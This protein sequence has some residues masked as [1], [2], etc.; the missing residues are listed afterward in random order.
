MKRRISNLVCYD[1]NEKGQTFSISD[2]GE[3][4]SC[5]TTLRMNGQQEEVKIPRR[6]P[7]LSNISSIDCGKD[8]CLC[9]DNEGNVFSFGSNQFGQIGVEG[10]FS[11]AVSPERI[12]LPLVKQVSCGAYFNIYVTED[13]DVYSNGEN[14]YG[15]L[16]MGNTKD[17]SLPQKII[18][19]ENVDFVQCGLDFV[20]CKTFDNG[21]IYVWGCNT[22]GQLGTED[23]KDR[24][25]PVKN[26][27]WPN[28]IIDIK[29]GYEHT[30]VLTEKQQVF[31]CGSNIC[32][33]TGLDVNEYKFIKLQKIESL[34]EIIRIECGDYHSMCIDIYN[35]LYVF[36][37]NEFGQLGLGDTDNRDEPI[38]HP[39]LSNIIDIS[40]GGNH[41]FVKTCE[42]IILGFGQS[43]KY[44]LGLETKDETQLL[45]IRVFED[46]EYIWYSN[47]VSSKTKSARK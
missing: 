11:F 42:N 2:N 15:Q 30:L 24:R 39:S 6:I 16:G 29:C 12:S 40:K 44:Q 8:H 26:V 17:F 36:G 5:G 3:V 23:K 14:N 10:S 19:L 38:K 41:V 1:G 7:E 25:S 21:E 4:Y 28:D 43:E 33:Q 27:D 31:S 45:P 34:S 9:L 13:G 35:D 20:I 46:I 37:D 32:G 18:S 22:E 47:F